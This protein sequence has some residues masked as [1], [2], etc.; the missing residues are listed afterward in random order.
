MVC[1]P[2]VSFLCH[3]VDLPHAVTSSNLFKY[4]SPCHGN[5]L[6]KHHDPLQFDL[7]QLHDLLAA[8]HEW[9]RR[10]AESHPDALHPL[11]IWNCLPRAGASQFHGHAQVML[12]KVRVDT[13][14]AVGL[15][16]WG[17]LHW[18]KDRSLCWQCLHHYSHCFAA[19]VL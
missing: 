7:E 11:F 4:C 15:W 17:I 1:T 5:V 2:S 12:S 18:D 6:F 19:P 3:R 14:K 13:H 9:L 10:A 16:S 8:A